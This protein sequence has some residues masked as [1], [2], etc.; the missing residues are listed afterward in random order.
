MTIDHNIYGR[1]NRSDFGVYGTRRYPK[2]SAVPTSAEVPGIPTDPHDPNSNPLVVQ[3]NYSA[4]QIAPHVLTE[5]WTYT[6]PPKRRGRIE[7]AFSTVLRETAAAPVGGYF[8][9][10][11]LTR[12]QHVAIA[13]STVIIQSHDRRNAVGD[14]VALV[15]PGP[16]ELFEG[17]V[18][19]A[20]TVDES[21]GGL[22]RYLA[23]VTLIE[24]DSLHPVIGSQASFTE[25]ATSG[26]AGI[27]PLR[28]GSTGGFSAKF[29]TAEAMTLARGGTVVESQIAGNTGIIPRRLRGTDFF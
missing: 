28:G 8:A 11:R 7:T 17:D 9:R 6:C 12:A 24:Y 20:D 19:N 1:L 13:V 10:V 25:G 29:P 14:N 3:L 23:S 5:R 16:I 4:S 21:T 27:A 22:V 15:N 26:P 18:L 2:G